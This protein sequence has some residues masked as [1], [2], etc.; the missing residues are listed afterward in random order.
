MYGHEDY[1]LYPR[2]LVCFLRR[3]GSE[4]A[5]KY[6]RTSITARREYGTGF[7]VLTAS[8]RYVQA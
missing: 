1:E 2:P 3:A 4:F 5:A 8:L 6:T 7:M